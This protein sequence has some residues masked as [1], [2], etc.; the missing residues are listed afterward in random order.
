MAV[1]EKKSLQTYPLK[2]SHAK[3][4]HICDKRE[5]KASRELSDFIE[6]EIKKHSE[7]LTDF[8]VESK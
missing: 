1:P 6:R 3:Y 5:V 8:K 4:I 7:H 2:T